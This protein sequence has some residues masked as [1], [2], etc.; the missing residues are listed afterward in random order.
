[1]GGSGWDIDSRR[2][3]NVVDDSGGV[4]CLDEYGDGRRRSGLGA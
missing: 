1:M 3:K 2:P 4:D